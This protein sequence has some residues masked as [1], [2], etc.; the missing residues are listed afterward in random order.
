MK[1]RWLR[2]PVFT[3]RS[4]VNY[5]VRW[6]P[7]GDRKFWNASFMPTE[8]FLLGD[9]GSKEKKSPLGRYI[10]IGCYFFAIYRGY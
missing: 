6:M 3:T 2:G 7:K 9:K 4:G 8:Y 10:S 5:A 1:F